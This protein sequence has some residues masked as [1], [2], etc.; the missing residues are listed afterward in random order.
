MEQKWT[1]KEADRKGESEREDQKQRRYF[2]S[3][4]PYETRNQSQKE[5]QEKNKYMQT[6]QQ[7]TENPI[8]NNEIK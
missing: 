6:K 8:G 1:R 5:K 4:K 2:L 7:S 3:P